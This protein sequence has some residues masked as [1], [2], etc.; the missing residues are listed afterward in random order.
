VQIV[1]FADMFIQALVSAAETAELAISEETSVGW[2]L[3][4][5]LPHRMGRF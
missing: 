5:F 1:D 3:L 2:P 4:G